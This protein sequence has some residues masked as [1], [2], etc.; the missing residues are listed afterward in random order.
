[1][2]KPERKVGFQLLFS[3][4]AYV[5]DPVQGKDTMD[6]HH[7]IHISRVLSGRAHH[8]IKWAIPPHRRRL[9]VAGL[10]DSQ[11]IPN[12]L[13][14]CSC[15]PRYN[16][17]SVFLPELIFGFLTSKTQLASGTPLDRVL[18]FCGGVRL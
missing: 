12:T 7:T 1:M 3:Y 15:P 11:C 5:T 6:S 13:N 10:I 2:S 17:K 14:A 18:L 4:N 9:L 16:K 8:C